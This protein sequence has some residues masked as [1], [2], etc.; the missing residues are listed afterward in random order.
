MTQSQH[1]PVG[2]LAEAGVGLE[3]FGE[4]SGALAQLV[5]ERGL[6]AG[7]GRPQ[8]A[9]RRVT[10]STSRKRQRATHWPSS[11]P[12]LI[13]SWCPSASGG[14]AMAAAPERASVEFPTRLI[15]AQASRSE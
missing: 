4:L 8:R 9:T 10:P 3:H 14:R 11:R 12:T 6:S 5:L 15:S 7:L 13:E 2:R 1:P